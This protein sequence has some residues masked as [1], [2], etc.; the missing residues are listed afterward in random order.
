MIHLVREISKVC[1]FTVLW[2]LPLVMS[3]MFDSNYYLWFFILSIIATAG[4]FA[5]YEDLEKID[6]L[7]SNGN[8]EQEGK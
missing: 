7:K 3:R 5:H 8:D 6:L 4:M 2:A 1:M